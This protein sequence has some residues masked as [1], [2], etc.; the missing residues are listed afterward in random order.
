MSHFLRSGVLNLNPL[1][2][3]TKYVQVSLVIRGRYVP[4]FWTVN[5]EFADNKSILDLKVVILDHF[6]QKW[7]SEF[8]DKKSAY[9]EG[10]L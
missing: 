9:D 4:L 3:T 10:R 1:I 7:I 8:A 5:L 2:A 6:F